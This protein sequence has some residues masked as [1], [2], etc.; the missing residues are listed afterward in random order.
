M[1]WIPPSS[2]DWYGGHIALETLIKLYIPRNPF[3]R[4]LV[5][6]MS[7]QRFT[8]SRVTTEVYLR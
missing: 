8:V 3:Q 7:I 4:G 2:L 5:S 1:L 6:Q